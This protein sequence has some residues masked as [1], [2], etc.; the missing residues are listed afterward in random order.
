MKVKGDIALL[1]M[2]GCLISG[3]TTTYLAKQQDLAQKRDA[4]KI[5]EEQYQAA[6]KK[7]RDTLPM[8]ERGAWPEEPP[9]MVHGT[10]S[11]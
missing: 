11:P 1:I 5:S 4:G 9:P 8:A 2:A 7:Q 6:L 3:C 10:I